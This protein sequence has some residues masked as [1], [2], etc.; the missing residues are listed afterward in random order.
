MLCFSFYSFFSLS[1]ISL[2]LA[3]LDL[4][5][6]IYTA[7]AINSFLSLYLNIYE[8]LQHGKLVQYTYACTAKDFTSNDMHMLNLSSNLLVHELTITTILEARDPIATLLA[9][10]RHS[11][12]R[13]QKTVAEAF[14]YTYI[15]N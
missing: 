9:V 10:S 13:R 12:D 11:F 14:I 7:I 2:I 1:H 3:L 4:T 6:P 5:S 15:P 8:S